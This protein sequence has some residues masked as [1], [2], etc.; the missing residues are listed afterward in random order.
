[1]ISTYKIFKSGIILFSIIIFLLLIIF[2]INAI[3][4]QPDWAWFDIDFENE[5]VSNYGTLISGLLSFL[6]ILFVIFGIV[7]ERE[8]REKDKQEEKNKVIENYRN[9]LKLLK[10]LLIK[11]TDEIKEQGKRMSEYYIQELKHPTQPN[12]TYFS[13]NKSFNR[14]IEMD[15][16][17]NYESIQYFFENDESWEKMF[18]NLNSYV[19]FYS[20]VLIEHKKKYQNHIQDKVSR[21]KEISNLCLDFLNLCSKQIEKYKIY[22]GD[23]YLEQKWVVLCNDFIPAYYDYLEECETKQ[24][25]TNFKVL[26]DT[27]FLSFLKEAMKHREEIGLDDYYSEELIHLAAKIRKKIYEVEMYS[28]QYAENIK[29]YFNEYFDENCQ[30]IKNLKAITQRISNKLASD[31]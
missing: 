19:D 15:Y 22:I 2:T 9:R 18:L 1:M 13:A 25:A 31:L 8:K 26:S 4:D 3:N 14:I 12:I 27:F 11:I 24:E 6:A 5:K 30:D 23:K 17:A 21:H 20:E 29:Y 10:S 7:E 16:I 28:I